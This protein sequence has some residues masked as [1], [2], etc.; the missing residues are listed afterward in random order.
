M[1]DRKNFLDREKEKR[2]GENYLPYSIALIPGLT[3][4]EQD[5][6]VKDI[7][8]GLVKKVDKSSRSIH[9][10]IEDRKIADRVEKYI[11]RMPEPLRDSWLLSAS[12]VNGSPSVIPGLEKSGVAGF[13]SPDSRKVVLKESSFRDEPLSAIHEYAHKMN[14]DLNLEHPYYYERGF[15]LNTAEV[16][17]RMVGID[18]GDKILKD[19][20]IMIEGRRLSTVNPN[21]VPNLHDAFYK[22]GLLKPTPIAKIG[23]KDA[24]EHTKAVQALTNDI[25][26]LRPGSVSSQQNMLWPAGHDLDYRD[27]HAKYARN[28]AEKLLDRGL[29][30]DYTTPDGLRL[31][32]EYMEKDDIARNA[33]LSAEG[34]AEI[35]EVLAT[36]GGE[37][38]IKSKFPTPYEAMMDEY[39]SDPRRVTPK[40]NLRPWRMY[41]HESPENVY[42]LRGEAVAYDPNEVRH[43]LR[44]PTAYGEYVYSDDYS[45]SLKNMNGAFD[46]ALRRS[47]NFVEYRDLDGKWRR[48]YP[49]EL[50]SLTHKLTTTKDFAKMLGK[51][52]LKGVK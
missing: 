12:D 7:A 8:E 17:D 27:N 22:A 30:R 11:Q 21:T 16:P 28:N 29:T 2:D 33:A 4:L 44:V 25:M 9:D 18:L 31:G 46:N 3:A 43:V 45:G 5:A 37:D 24:R 1:A 13:Y 34:A 14:H 15:D 19:M 50:K 40:E 23:D 38:Y 32:I 26:N 42:K 20:P 6:L 35:A 36:E 49:D 51:K 48:Y 52:I 41:S 10:Y 47:R 39:R